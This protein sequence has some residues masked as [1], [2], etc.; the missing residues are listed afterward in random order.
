[1]SNIPVRASGDKPLYLPGVESGLKPGLHKDLIDSAR[2]RGAEYPKIWDL[3]AFQP[4]FTASL[5]H[6]TH[7]VL[8]TPATISPAMR[9][10]IAAWTSFRNECRFC[11]RAHAAAASE[12][13][14]SEELVRSVMD[15]LETS[16]LDE[17]DKTMLRFVTKITSDLPAVTAADVERVRAAGWDDEAIYYAIT[18]CA[19]FNFYNRWITATGVAEMSGEAHRLQGRHLARHGYVRKE[20]D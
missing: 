10:L 6:F 12:L 1:M 13:L 4:S 8:R 9:E 14:G 20:T 5:A 2:A 16:P 17:K 11:T 3:F 18:T 19:L 15:N 7:G